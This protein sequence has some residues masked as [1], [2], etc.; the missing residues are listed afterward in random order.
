MSAQEPAP[1]RPRPGQEYEVIVERLAYGGEGVARLPPGPEA[2]GAGGMTVFVA[3]AAPG[4]RARVRL[5]EV[6]RRHA[7][8]RLLE[9]I[10][11]GPERVP[12]VCSHYDEGCGGCSWQHLAIAAQQRAKVEAVR[13]SLVRIGGYADPP[14][15]PVRAAP[16]AWF[17]RNKME[18][19]FSVRGGLGLHPVGRWREVV[20]ITDCRLQ[21]P[22]AMR[23]LDT[24]RAF[25]RDHGLPA[26]D[27]VTR[28]G[29]LRDLAI[30]HARATGQT[31]V[32][33]V[34]APGP[35]PQAGD[36]VAR[37]RALDPGICAV[38]RGI[39]PGDNDG[40]PI[41][42]VEAL[43]GGG[44][45]VEEVRGLRFEVGLQT[46]FQTNTAQAGAL[47]DVVRELAGD[48]SA[49][50]ASPRVLDV[51]CGVGFFTLALAGQAREVIGVELSEA[52]I[53]AARANA[54]ENRIANVA[55]F[56]GDARHVLPVALAAH[57][58][59]EVVVLDPPRSGAGGK[60][61]RRIA[62]TGA[63]RIVYV[64]CNPATLA[65]DLR[66]LDPFGYRMTVVQPV[67]LFPQTYHVETVVALDRSTAPIESPGPAGH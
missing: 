26:W 18:F 49:A 55:F 24:V 53:E 37:L 9:V 51:F 31:L 39:R 48:G 60:V 21:S 15:S 12:A 61:M 47:L 33:L 32:G 43:H 17:Y 1:A 28:Q 35:L 66:E 42:A 10:A 20:P 58:L 13:E 50:G 40:S 25:A 45:I 3:G 30:R 65:R 29:F 62:R 52:S 41:V 5:T 16:E 46:F 64:S 34:T 38:V 8:A 11:P 27:A 54:R 14:M 67:D 36:L 2:S 19:A 4:D 63:R 57:G 22:L 59:P 23:I 6:E 7:R 44:T 56:A